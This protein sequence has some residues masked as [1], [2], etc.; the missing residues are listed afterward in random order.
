M[1]YFVSIN[2]I[3]IWSFFTKHYVVFSFNTLQES[4]ILNK[5][6]TKKL[7]EIKKRQVFVKIKQQVLLRTR[8]L[9]NP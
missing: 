4:K 6:K 9:I 5:L 3:F 8:K 2:F 7:R 1:I